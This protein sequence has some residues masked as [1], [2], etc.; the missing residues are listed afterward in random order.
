[1]SNVDFAKD[2]NLLIGTP[3]RG[4]VHH[5]C[6]SSILVLIEFLHAR[7]A[8]VRW[9]ASTQPRTVPEKR[10]ELVNV[11][12]TKGFT[13]LL[14][15]DSDIQFRPQP[16]FAMLALDVPVVGC[17]Y[18]GRY[19]SPTPR[20][21][22]VMKYLS[23][24]EKEERGCIKVAGLGLGLALFR[25]DCLEKM[26]KHYGSALA[27]FHEPLVKTK[28]G[29]EE[30]HEIQGEDFAFFD[31][32]RV[33]GGGEVLC[34]LDSFVVHHVGS[35]IGANAKEILFAKPAEPSPVALAP[36]VA[37]PRFPPITIPRRAR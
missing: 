26:V 29:E 20:D 1:V 9:A 12:L 10:A 23:A 13:H 33:P 7:G 8:K 32:W 15:V 37:G 27:C 2:V 17:A 14:F 30:Q 28:I 5:A 31:R 18:P 16:I 6:M 34:Y 22:L 35:A 19:P 3:T 4:E 36:G 21:R 25:R 11:T 24:D